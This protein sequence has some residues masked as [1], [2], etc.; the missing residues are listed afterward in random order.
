MIDNEGTLQQA[1]RKLR[2]CHRRLQFASRARAVTY[3]RRRMI[4]RS[5]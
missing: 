4:Y 3:V 5:L 1:Q 2:R